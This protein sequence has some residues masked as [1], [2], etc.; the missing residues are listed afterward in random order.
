MRTTAAVDDLILWLAAGVLALLWIGMAGASF[1]AYLT[2]A[3]ARSSA[4]Q[5]TSC[6]AVGT[7]ICP[8][9]LQ[10]QGTWGA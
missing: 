5:P 3:E 4:V 9:R 10:G 8:S 7:S 6:S 1:G 2:R